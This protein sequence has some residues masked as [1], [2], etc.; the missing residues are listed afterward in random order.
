MNPTRRNPRLNP[1]RRRFKEC[2]AR[3]ALDKYKP[4]RQMSAAVMITSFCKNLL[5]EENTEECMNTATLIKAE[6][7]NWKLSKP[8]PGQSLAAHRKWLDC[9]Q[10]IEI[11][12]LHYFPLWEKEVHDLLQAST[13]SA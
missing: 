9:W 5:G 4:I 7:Y 11:A 6:R 8:L 10:N 13:S 3:C 12:D 2:I 1:T